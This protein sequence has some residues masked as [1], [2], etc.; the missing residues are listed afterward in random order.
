MDCLQN[1][2]GLKAGC[3]TISS[4]AN[5]YLNSLPGCSMKSIDAVANSEQIS[6]KGVFDDL[7]ARSTIR[8]RTALASKLAAKYRLKNKI[9]Q[10]DLKRIVNTTTNQTPLDYEYRGFTIQ[11]STLSYFA[12]IYIEKLQL[13]AASEQYTTIKIFDVITGEELYTSERFLTTIGWNYITIQNHFSSKHIFVCY[14]SENITSVYQ[15]IDELNVNGGVY[16]DSS[17]SNCTSCLIF[18]S[19]CISFAINGASSL[20]SSPTEISE[21]NNLFGLSAILSARCKY[22]NLV[23]SNTDIYAGAWLYCLGS[24]YMS[25]R[26]ISDRL[27]EYTTTNIDDALKFKEIFDAEFEKELDNAIK[28]T[29]INLDAECC[30]ECNAQVQVVT[31]IP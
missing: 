1:L 13:Y 8:F 10:Y 26:M 14:N 6:Y 31:M 20:I 9:Q 7:K 19:E 29:T 23:C 11:S 12:T 15:P 17:F 24:E 5:L 3:N 2:V 16:G 4:T 18:N 25:E 21:A 22:D 30:V 28:G 27:N